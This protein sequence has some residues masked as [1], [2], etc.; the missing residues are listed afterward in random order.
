MQPTKPRSLLLVGIICAAAGWLIIRATFARL[1]ALPWTGVPA[2]V[3]LA[4]GEVLTGRNLRAR[5]SGRGKPVQPMAVAR[6]AALAK[7]SSAVA[8]AVGG[9]AAGF[10]LYVAGS[11]A[12]SLPRTDELAAAATLAAALGLIAAALYLE[13]SCRTP[14]E[15]DDDLP[16]DGPDMGPLA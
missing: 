12:K 9:L 5:L 8:A 6:I 16:P 3:L 14:D 7:A 2:I 15:P 4:V 1:P 11:L 13:R 10:A